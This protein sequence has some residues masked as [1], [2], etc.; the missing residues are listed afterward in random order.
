[1]EEED[2]G[3]VAEEEEEEEANAKPGAPKLDDPIPSICSNRFGDIGQC[4][5]RTNRRRFLSNFV[6]VLVEFLLLWP[7]L[8]LLLLEPPDPL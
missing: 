3:E 4:A 6:F 1:M 7:E 8:A 2:D 5:T